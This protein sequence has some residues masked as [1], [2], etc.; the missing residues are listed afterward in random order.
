M[1]RDRV[2]AIHISRA[3]AAN[4]LSL[5]Q[6][7][8]PNRRERGS[9]YA[10]QVKCA[11]KSNRK[12]LPRRNLDSP[13]HSQHDCDLRALLGIWETACPSAREEFLSSVSDRQPAVADPVT[14]AV[15]RALARM[16]PDD[17]AAR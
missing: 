3:L 5:C 4:A 12:R 11:V 14:A 13:A 15:E 16:L 1:I 9:E 7:L 8:F 6:R 10:V 2:P 17:G